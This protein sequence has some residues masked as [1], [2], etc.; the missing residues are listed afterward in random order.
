MLL[1]MEVNLK[2]VERITFISVIREIFTIVSKDHLINRDLE[3]KKYLI[4]IKFR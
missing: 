2:I 4:M 3:E 1:I